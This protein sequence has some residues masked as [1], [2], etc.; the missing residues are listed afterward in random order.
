MRVAVRCFLG[1]LFTATASADVYVQVTKHNYFPTGQVDC[2]FGI[3]MPVQLDVWAWGDGSDT[4]LYSAMFDIAPGFSDM[5][6]IYSLGTVDPGHVFNVRSA[7]AI[8]PL[9]LYSDTIES[10]QMVSFDSVALPQSPQSALRLY[11]GFTAAPFSA[12][13]LLH[14]VNLRIETDGGSSPIVHS[15]GVRET[16][17]PGMAIF[18]LCGAALAWRWRRRHI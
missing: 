2:G 8:K 10:I 6:S 1:F 9:G 3:A 14:A 15:I 4:T 13:A 16:P 5:W 18:L 7:G 12:G 11:S 17:E